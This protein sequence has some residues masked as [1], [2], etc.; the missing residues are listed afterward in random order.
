MSGPT[1]GSDPNGVRGALVLHDVLG[2]VAVGDSG[3]STSHQI[4]TRVPYLPMLRV[5]IVAAG[6]LDRVKGRGCRDTE[7]PPLRGLSDPRVQVRSVDVPSDF[8]GSFS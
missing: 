5:T 2:G 3:S 7:D 8:G 6:G 4:S 1:K